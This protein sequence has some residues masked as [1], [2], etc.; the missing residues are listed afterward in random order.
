[1]IKEEWW[2]WIAGGVGLIILIAFA[3]LLLKCCLTRCVPVV[4]QPPGSNV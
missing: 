1:M 3:I 2:S 4:A